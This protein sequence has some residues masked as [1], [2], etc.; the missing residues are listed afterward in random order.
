MKDAEVLRSTDLA[1]NAR[2]GGMTGPPRESGTS[3]SPAQ[4]HACQ[5]CGAEALNGNSPPFSSTR[6]G[7]SNYV[8]QA[9]R[10]KR[11]SGRLASPGRQLA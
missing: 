10:W 6:L 8:F 7:G 5:R 3:T 1:D 9:C 4:T 2:P 11:N